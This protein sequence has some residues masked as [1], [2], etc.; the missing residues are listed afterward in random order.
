MYVNVNIN[1]NMYTSNYR[2]LQR[3]HRAREGRSVE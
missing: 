1:I 2:I 3:Q